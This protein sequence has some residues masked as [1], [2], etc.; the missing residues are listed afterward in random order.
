MAREWVSHGKVGKEEGSD[1]PSCGPLLQ[2]AKSYLHFRLARLSAGQRSRVV[3][4]T[5]ACPPALTELT[6]VEKGEH[7]C[8]RTEV[9]APTEA[10][11][12][13]SGSRLGG[14][15]SCGGS[16]QGYD[17][18]EK[19]ESQKVGRNASFLNLSADVLIGTMGTITVIF[20]IDFL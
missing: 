4:Q 6:M 9:A 5:Q 3:T 16:G 8:L 15:F 12:R 7:Q 13:G 11:A 19:G 14:R 2:A 10:T 18:E 20:F 1:R 17:E